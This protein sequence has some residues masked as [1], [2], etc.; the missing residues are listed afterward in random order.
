MDG[1]RDHLCSSYHNGTSCN[2]LTT[3]G[4][5]WLIWPALQ[6]CCKCCSY[7]NGCGP[8][9]PAWVGNSSGIVRYEGLVPVT[10]HRTQM[11]CHKW[12]IPG[13]SDGRAH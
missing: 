1:T 3:G 10:Y 9:L 2:M 11:K 4:W 6:T 12:R 5:K 8:L 13:L 7:A